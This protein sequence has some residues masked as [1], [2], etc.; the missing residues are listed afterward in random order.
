MSGIYG[1]LTDALGYDVRKTTGA[2]LEGLVSAIAGGVW[3]EGLDKMRLTGGVEWKIT[4]QQSL[5]AA[6]IW[7]DKASDDEAS[8]SAISLS[9]KYSF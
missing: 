3:P 5:E 1:S 4:K 8:G 2:E 7:Q 9:Y 6:Y